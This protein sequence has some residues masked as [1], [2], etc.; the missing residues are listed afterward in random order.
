MKKF[1]MILCGALLVSAAMAAP[2][3]KK[4]A[5]TKKTT[6]AKP[7]LSELEKRIKNGAA[8][9]IIV[10]GSEVISAPPQILRVSAQSFSYRADAT[11][12]AFG[13]TILKGDEKNK[14]SVTFL[15]SKGQAPVEI[16]ASEIEVETALTEIHVNFHFYKDHGEIPYGDFSDAFKDAPRSPRFTYIEESSVGSMA[17]I[18]I[19][20]YDRRTKNL[21][22]SYA[23]AGWDDRKY[24]ENR[25]TEKNIT[26]EII[27]KRGANATPIPKKNEKPKSTPK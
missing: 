4:V 2:K 20:I 16:S 25:K 17:Y 26:E 6:A 3:S 22:T 18:Q 7:A 24:K 11:G 27:Q 15:K 1:A 12:G 19:V 10:T 14:A 5:A 8:T 9:K 21:Y 13:R 23:Y